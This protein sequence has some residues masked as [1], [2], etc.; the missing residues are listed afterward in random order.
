MHQMLHQF[1]SHPH[2]IPYRFATCTHTHTPFNSFNYKK[3][4]VKV[5]MPQYSSGA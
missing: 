4:N 3:V 5:K 1:Y 2:S